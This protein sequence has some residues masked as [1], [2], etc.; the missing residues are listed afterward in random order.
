MFACKYVRVSDSVTVTFR[1]AAIT[2][3]ERTVLHLPQQHQSIASVISSATNPRAPQTK[4]SS[5]RGCIISDC[6]T[7]MLT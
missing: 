6:M 5:A 1:H 3:V 7:T 2:S 4:G